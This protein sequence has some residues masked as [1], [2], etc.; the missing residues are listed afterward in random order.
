MSTISPTQR[1]LAYFEEQ[2]YMCGMVERFIKI[3]NLPGGGIRKDLFNIIDIIAIRENEIVGV[4]SCGS[5]FAGHQKKI[6]GENKDKLSDWL[7][8]GGKFYLIG[9][10]KVKKVRGQKTMVWKP[11]IIELTRVHI[12]EDHTHTRRLERTGEALS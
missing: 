1:T 12:D 8:A 4:Q 11:R 5:D 6:L 2:G 9:W 7:S 10:R 3:P